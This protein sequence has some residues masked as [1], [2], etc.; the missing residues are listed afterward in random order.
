MTGNSSA[1]STLTAAGKSRGNF[2]AA[3]VVKSAGLTVLFGNSFNVT[4]GSSSALVQSNITIQANTTSTSKSGAG[5]TAT[6]LKSSGTA[7]ASST[8]G[9]PAIEASASASATGHTN[10]TTTAG[11]P[12]STGGAVALGVST[13][14]AYLAGFGALVAAVAL[15]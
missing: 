2:S 8:A 15:L 13:N 6:S 11:S 4:N 10:A 9:G 14:G 3:N 12:K 7:K 1:L 5:T